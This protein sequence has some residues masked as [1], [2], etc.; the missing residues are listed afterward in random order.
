MLNSGPAASEGAPSAPASQPAAGA[1]PSSAPVDGQ[2]SLEGSIPQ[3]QEAP[4]VDPALG[5]NPADPQDPPKTPEEESFSKRFAHLAKRERAVMERER[6]AKETLQKYDPLIKAVESGNAMAVL[7]HMGISYQDLTNIVLNDGKKPDPTAEERIAQLEQQL[8]DLR[9]A[10]DDDAQKQENDK[11]ESTINQ[12][13][14]TLKAAIDNA[15]DDY[16][17][18]VAHQAYDAVYEVIEQHFIQ[19]LEEYGEGELLPWNEAAGLVEKHL[20]EQAQPFLKAK[21]FQ[22]KPP[23]P[24]GEQPAPTPT[25]QRPEASSAPTLS[26]DMVSPAAAPSGEYLSEEESKRRLAERLRWK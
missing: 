3:P 18:V 24:T 2:P 6:V 4:G 19:T 5:D 9:Q 12:H 20:E 14:A 8:K 25:G 7:Q 13:K 1:A 10:K 21:K 22:P 26:N 23:A 15:A 17:L 16:E 11:I